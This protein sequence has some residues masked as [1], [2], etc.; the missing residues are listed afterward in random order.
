MTPEELET[1]QQLGIT[2]VLDLRTEAESKAHPDPVLPGVTMIR[3]S[4]VVSKGGEEIDFS[5][6]GMNQIGEAGD[7]QLQE[8][9]KYYCEM[10]FGNN[11]FQILIK[12][13]QKGHLPICFHCATGK[14]R[15]GVAAMILLLLLGV[16]E[17]TVFEDYMLSCDYRKKEIEET[18]AENADRIKE[19][20]VLK[21][22][23]TMKDGV[24][25]KIGHAVLQ[26]ITHRYGSL[27]EYFLREFHLTE[28][29]ITELRNKY[30]Q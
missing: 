11:A 27:E 21:E 30:L 3:H 20:P 25:E 17:E 6:K 24:S 13:I 23:L 9:T 16:D 1:F 2:N 10:P 4:G 14:D 15:T 5:P 7:K 28:E 18:L 26:E 8:L 22:L 12:E 19:S 29:D